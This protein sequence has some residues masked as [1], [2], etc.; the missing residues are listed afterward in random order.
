VS[1]KQGLRKPLIVIVSPALAAANN[2][3]WQTASRWARM[4]GSDFHVRIVP[5]WQGQRCDA[6]IALH[7]RRSA[8][9]IA[10]FAQAHPGHPLVVVLTGT[11]LYRDIH[12]DAA[13]QRSLVLA[14]RLVTLQAQGPQELPTALRRRCVVLHQS[15]PRLA[16]ALKPRTF[17]R[18]VQVG[19]LRDEK[20]PMTFMR[21]AQRLAA[22]RDIRFEQIGDALDP[23]LADAARA[24]AALCPGYHWVGAMAH[25]AARQRIRRA[26]LLVNTSRIEGGANVVIEAAQ[27]GTAVLASRIG[28]N[29]GLLGAKHSGVFAAGDDAALAALIERARDDA[30]FLGELQAQTQERTALFDPVRE[31]EGLLHLL[32]DALEKAP[33][34]GH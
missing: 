5:S 24:T 9:S 11:D 31:R 34:V 15:A 26:H 20:D 33:D 32:H 23:V 19:H 29:V 25:A 14:T 3:N 7:A 12:V 30:A 10:A 6:L 4:L 27:S 2:G 8:A 21:A 17:L 28:G 16:P 1:S 22:R 13:A 18:V